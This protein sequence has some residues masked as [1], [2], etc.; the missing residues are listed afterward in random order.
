MVGM[1]VAYY[2][3]AT[4]SRLVSNARR[5]QGCRRIRIQFVS[6]LIARRNPA[7][8]LKMADAK[9]RTVL[10]RRLGRT[11]FPL[12]FLGSRRVIIDAFLSASRDHLR[13]P[14][15]FAVVLKKVLV[16]QFIYNSLFAAPYTIACF[17]FKNQH[18]RPSRTAHVFTAKFLQEQVIPALWRN[19]GGM[20]P[21]TSA[22][23]ALP[24]LLQIPLFA[25]AL[26][27][28]RCS[29]LISRPARLMRWK[30]HRWRRSCRIEAFFLWL[31]LPGLCCLPRE[32][33]P[34]EIFLKMPR[35]PAP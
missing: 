4:R 24:P 22:I 32:M 29:S 14:P 23:Y 10:A 11:D 21:V 16:D 20:D 5:G 9:S 15:D 8:D 13:R 25:L 2:A 34:N 28:C 18:Y 31:P 1:V 6:A 12:H 35:A 26:T 33:T 19:V 30:W 27:F 3:L 7:R 17:E